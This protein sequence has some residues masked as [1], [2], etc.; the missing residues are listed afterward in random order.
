MITETTRL[1]HQKLKLAGAALLR[2]HFSN[3]RL[4]SF[5]DLRVSHS[6]I[7]RSSFS[8][9]IRF[10]GPHTRVLGI[11]RRKLPENCRDI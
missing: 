10:D 11:I 9:H 2:R 5:E 1:L 3:D 6:R 4:R 8:V 7:K